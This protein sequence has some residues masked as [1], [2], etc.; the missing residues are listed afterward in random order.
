MSKISNKIIEVQEIVFNQLKRL[1][2]N[3]E[4]EI[5]SKEEIERANVISH[6]ILLLVYCMQ[7]I[8]NNAQTFIK[9]LNM[10]LSIMQYADKTENKVSYMY[11]KLGLTDELENEE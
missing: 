8:S 7:V 5:K 11:N 10:Q 6:N 3:E 9:T 2:D 1:D 4:M